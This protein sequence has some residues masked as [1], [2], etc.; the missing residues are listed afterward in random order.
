M[1]PFAR[2]ILMLL[3]VL[4][5]AAC[6]GQ[7]TRKTAP[8][9]ADAGA[10]IEADAQPHYGASSQDPWEGFNRKMYA[11]NHVLDQALLRPVMT[12]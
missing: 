7:N 12:L 2:I 1:N 6:A 11:F 3:M 10:G 5:L 4:A 9:T 8:E